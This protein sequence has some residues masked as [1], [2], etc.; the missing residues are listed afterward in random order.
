MSRT[1]R[2]GAAS[3]VLF[4][5]TAVV[6]ASMV[7]FHRLLSQSLGAAYAQLVALI[8]VS[9]VLSNVTLGVNTF[10][11]K[12]FAHDAEIKGP[13]AVAARLKGLLRPGL[14]GLGSLLALLLLLSPVLAAYLKLPSAALVAMVMALFAVGVLLLAL[15][16]AVQGLHHFGWL[17]L[18]LMGEG[19]GRVGGALAWGSGVAG[20]LSA[21]LLGQV[22]GIGLALAGLAGIG[23]AP[24]AAPASVQGWRKALREAGSD[25]AVLTLFAL[26]A[27]LDVMVLKHHLPDQQA[28]LYG[29]AALVAKSFLYLAGALNLV[30]LPAAS[31]ALAAGRDPRPLLLRFVGAAL[32]VDLLGLAFV[33]AFAPWCLRL[34][35]G[36]DPAFQAMAP[37]TRWFSLAV[38][39]LAL[40]QLSLAYLLA[41]RQ[42]GLPLAL[43]ALVLL[44][45]GLLEAAWRD[46]RLVVAALGGVSLLGLALALIAAL[47]RA[48]SP[49]DRSTDAL[50]A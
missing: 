36:P 20:A 31:R 43:A 50:Q 27:F 24:K 9:N 2:L 23:P 35:A 19:F 5:A 8:A 33:W 16:A 11:V 37:L 13:G 1:R 12:A 45:W 32:A 38:I 30:L 41:V 34:L 39:P 22:A 10:L 18:S 49:H 26:L 7:V 46:E 28:A 44:F 21:M 15:R 47:R 17:G 25:T 42:R 40:L 4:A 3:V 14:L 48:P 6:N 29:R